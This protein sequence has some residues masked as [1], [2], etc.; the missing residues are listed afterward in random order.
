M[1]ILLF[2]L[3]CVNYI[4]LCMGWN[5]LLE[6]GILGWMII[7]YLLDFMLQ[8]LIPLY[9]SCLWILI[10]FISLFTSS[11]SI[12]LHHLIQLVNSK[13]KLWYLGAA[14]FFFFWGLSFTL[15][16][17]VLYSGKIN[18]FM[19]Y[20]IEQVC[21]TAN[22]SILIFLPPNLLWCPIACFLI[23]HDFVKLLMLLN[24]LYL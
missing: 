15:L 9:S 10:Y 11:N 2:L 8:R 20:S 4:N 7:F 22:Q 24:I 18:I 23:L 17:W 13:F 1:L 21:L 6:H 5:K 12:L 3:M 14:Y 16:V 19:T